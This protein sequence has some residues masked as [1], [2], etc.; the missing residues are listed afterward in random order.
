VSRGELLTIKNFYEI[1]NGLITP[2]QM[3]GLLLT[4]FPHEE[5]NQTEDRKVA[6][7]SMGV[8]CLDCHANFHTN[9]AFHL[10]PD[11]GGMAEVEFGRIADNKAVT[12]LVKEFARRM[13]EDHSKTNDELAKIAKQANIPLPTQ[14][15]PDHQAVKSDLDKASGI[16][17]DRAYM[18]GQVIDHQKTTILLQYEIGQGQDAALQRFAA[19]TLPTVMVHLEMARNLLAEL[20]DPAIEERQNTT[21]RSSALDSNNGRKRK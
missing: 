15:A 20:S 7:Q 18:H 17:F 11:G 6:G 9:G 14:L 10:T 5:F 2:V 8:T 12:D 4:P 1:M 21:G 3:E 16:N 13:I 19:E